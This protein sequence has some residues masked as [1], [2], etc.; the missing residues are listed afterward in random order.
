MRILLMC[1]Q[2]TLAGMVAGLLDASGAVAQQPS[3]AQPS[4]AVPQALPSPTTNSV[5]ADRPN[6]AEAQKLAP[7]APP[8]IATAADKLPVDQLKAPRGFKLEVYASGMV[9]ARSLARGDKGT[10]F[11]STRLLDRIY[12]ITEKDGKREVKPLFSG[13]LF[14]PNGIAFKDGTLYIA[15]LNKISKVE[16]IEDNLDNPPKPVVIYSDLPSDEPHGWKYLTIGP[17]NKL[18]FQVGA[19]CNICLPDDR[20]ARIYLPAISVCRRRRMPR[21]AVSIWMVAAPK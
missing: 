21:S 8:P 16:H 3:P 4:A 19:P 2:L 7:V 20:H 15:E 14:R 5:M 6:T 10:I 1:F 9:N 12:A 13:T 17:D 11:V 18:Y